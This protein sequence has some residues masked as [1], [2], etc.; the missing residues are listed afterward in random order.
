M[1]VKKSKKVALENRRGSWLLMGLV[2]ALSFMFVSFEWTRHDLR[3]TAGSL[4]NE[5]FFVDELVPITYPETKAPPPPPPIQTTEVL[6][7]VENTANVKEA[8]VA[9]SE[10]THE[11]YVIKAPPPMIEEVVVETEIVDFAEK[12]PEYPGGSKAMMAYLNKNVKYPVRP[13]ET[14]IQ[15]RVIVQFVVERDGSISNLIVVRSVDPDLD[16]EALRVIEAM[17]KWTPGLQNGKPVRVKYTLPVY[18]KLQ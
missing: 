11:R 9:P 18:F 13:Q 3:I 7:I 1:E 5:P 15:G 14:G 8:T 17:P 4:V 16:K 12:M 6:V 10:E 2:T